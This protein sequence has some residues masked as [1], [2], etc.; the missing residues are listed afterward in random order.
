[1]ATQVEEEDPSA[2]PPSAAAS[3]IV[4]T[5]TYDVSHSK[6]SHAKYSHGKHSHGKHSHGKHSHSEY[7]TT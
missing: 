2:L 1:M 3:N 5:R 6:Y 7:S 4:R